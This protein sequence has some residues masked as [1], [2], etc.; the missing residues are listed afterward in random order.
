MN[1]TGLNMNDV[2]QSNISAV[3]YL[4]NREGELSRKDIAHKLGLTPAA[5]TKI[6]R[7]LLRQGKIIETGESDENKAGRK[8]IL[9][10]VNSDK[11]FVIGISLE[12]DY[13][14]YG[15]YNVA[16]KCVL[17][18]KKEF[19]REKE[20]ERLLG[21]ISSEISEM[22]QISGV[23]KK[24]ILGAGVGIVGSVDDDGVTKGKYGMWQEGVRV[25]EVFEKALK[26]PVE[27]EN[28]VKAFVI[29][30]TVFQTQ[31][32]GKNQL[33]IKWGP[34]VGSAIMINGDVFS[35][36]GNGEAEIGH[37]IINPD[38]AECRCGRK[39]CL[40]THV[41]AKAII[42]RIKTCYSKETTPVL[43]ELTKGNSDKI[44][45][46]LLL[47]NL[48]RLDEAVNGIIDRRINRMARAVVN[49]ATL[50][51]PDQVV[52]FGYMFDKNVC[53]KFIDCCK[54]YYPK[55][56][57][58]FISVST[59]SGES[60]YIGPVALALKNMFFEK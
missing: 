44:S 57:E 41:A 23:D 7:E 46:E 26:I 30:E 2:K 17:S 37:Y 8:K 34:G 55:Y 6:C 29:S 40:E 56:D 59:L 28:N 54:A 3:L 5:V 16:G 48:D 35:S 53:R 31:A 58:S 13:C 14:D 33:F 11:F 9:I 52:L 19:I 60:K 22:I 4:L 51:D 15:I 36:N 39:G 43:Y 50:F 21:E 38:G 47:K 24:D 12:P 20:P 27:V 18:G 42:D 10:S 25:R 1:F 49:A 45:Y 32:K